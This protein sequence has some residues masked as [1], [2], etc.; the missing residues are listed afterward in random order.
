MKHVRG[1]TLDALLK[2]PLEEYPLRRGL[3]D[4]DRICEAVAYSHEKGVVHRDIKPA[5]MMLG[6]HGAVYQIDWGMGPF[7][8]VCTRFEISSIL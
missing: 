4:F 5:N 3:S 2:K 1:E 6:A 7:F 8:G